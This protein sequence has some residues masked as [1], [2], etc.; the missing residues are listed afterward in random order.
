MKL[1]LK[2]SRR[3]D[4]MIHIGP[5]IQISSEFLFPF[6]L[7]AHTIQ[8]KT[9]EERTL[10]FVDGVEFVRGLEENTSTQTMTGFLRIV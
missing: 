6:P 8:W 7:S 3:A 2:S 4:T 5:A 9:K 10:H 1:K